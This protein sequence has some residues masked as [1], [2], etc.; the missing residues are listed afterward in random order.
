MC[1]RQAHGGTTTEDRR[2]PGGW[3]PPKLR[4]RCSLLT[5][6][7]GESEMS[8]P[9]GVHLV[10]GLSR[11]KA[12]RSLRWAPRRCG[13]AA[14]PCALLPPRVLSAVLERP[15]RRRPVRPSWLYRMCTRCGRS[16]AF[17]HPGFSSV[18]VSRVCPHVSCT[19]EAVS[20]GAHPCWPGQGQG[21]PAAG[22]DVA[23][24]AAPSGPGRVPTFRAQPHE[25]SVTGRLHTRQRH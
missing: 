24:V 8:S 18:P 10:P 6:V 21:S 2:G 4:P 23:T 25:V 19:Q 14:R 3:G 20:L 17:G 5:H 9:Y 16:P 15:P 12:G 11:G 13:P 22:T 7:L 1:Q